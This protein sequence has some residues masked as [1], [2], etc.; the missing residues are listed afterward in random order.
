MDILSPLYKG[1]LPSRARQEADSES[2]KDSVAA[3]HRWFMPFIPAPE[4]WKQE[5]HEFE[6]SLI[7]IGKPRF[8][9]VAFPMPM[10]ALCKVSGEHLL[11]AGPGRHKPSFPRF[12]GGSEAELWIPWGT[13][14]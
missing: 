4:R 9:V 8:N 14:N 6:S 12:L 3:S 1:Q 5:D 13:I 11:C 7:N 2:V 10:K